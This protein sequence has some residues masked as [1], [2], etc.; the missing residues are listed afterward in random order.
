MLDVRPREEY[1]GGHI[2]GAVSIPLEE[3]ADRLQEL[4]DG[5]QIVAYCRRAYCVLPTTPCGR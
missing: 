4:P 3:L 2:P 5:K 1:A